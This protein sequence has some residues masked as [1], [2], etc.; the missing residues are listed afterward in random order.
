MKFNSF[1]LKWIAIITMVIDHVGA[2]LFPHQMIFRIIGRIS[3]PIFCFLLVEGFFHTSNVK[4]Y[5]VRLGVFALL[6]EIPYDLAFR[7]SFVDIHKQNVFFALLIGLVMMYAITYTNN[8]TVKVIYLV[9]AMWAARMIACDYGYKGI[10]LIAVYYFFRDRLLVKTF[11]GALWNFLGGISLQMYGA[12]AS[13]PI[14]LYNGERG[15]GMKYIF[16]VFYPVHLLILYFI[17]SI[18]I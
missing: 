12:L 14:M 17:S 6:S 16:Y 9:L 10:L 1:Q 13:V 3:F 8:M 7:G 5:T 2:V 11:L 15:K 18:L 4:K